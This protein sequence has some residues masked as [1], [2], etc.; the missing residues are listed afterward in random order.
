MNLVGVE[1]RDKILEILPGLEKQKN[2]SNDA[3]TLSVVTFGRV[4]EGHGSKRSNSIIKQINLAVAAWASFVKDMEEVISTNMDVIGYD[5]S[6]DIKEMNREIKNFAEGYGGKSLPVRALQYM[7][8]PDELFQTI[9]TK[10]LYL[11]LSKEEG[12]GLCCVEAISLGIPVILSEATGLYQALKERKLENY[13]LSVQIDGRNESPYFTEDDLYNVKKK[14]YQFFHNKEKYKKDILELQERLED[15]G[16]S[17]EQSAR[18][19]VRFMQIDMKKLPEKICREAQM[20]TCQ[21]KYGDERWF[22]R[23]DLYEKIDS[24]YN[25]K[26]ILLIEGGCQSNKEVSVFWWA[27]SRGIDEGQLYYYDAQ[28]DR[29]TECFRIQAEN[30]LNSGIAS[31][32]KIYIFIVGFPGKEPK[33]Y[34]KVIRQMLKK[35]VKLYFII[36]TNQKFINLYE[37]G[38]Y[39]DF[40]KITIQGLSKENV[41]D[42][43]GL[44]GIDISEDEIEKLTPTE[45]LPEILNDYIEYVLDQESDVTEAIQKVEIDR[46]VP[47][48]IFDSLSEQEIMMAGVLA[49]FDTPFSKNIAEKMAKGRGISRK[50]IDRLVNKGVIFI[51]SKFSYKIPS[52]YKKYLREKVPDEEKIKAYLEISKHY[53]RSYQYAWDD[54]LTDEDIMRGINACKFAIKAQDYERARNY[55][56]EGKYSLK[57]RGKKKGMYKFLIPIMKELYKIFGETDKWLVYDFVH[58]LMITGDI[59]FAGNIL[60]RLDLDTVMDRDCRVALLRLKGELYCEYHGPKET[61]E[62]LSK[63]YSECGKPMG[64]HNIADEQM[65]AYLFNLQMH[66]GL[67]G[68]VLV[69][70]EEYMKMH[71]SNYLNAILLNYLSICKRKIN[72][73]QGTQRIDEAMQLFEKLDDERG[74]AW[75]KMEKGIAQFEK[76]SPEAEDTLSEA[77]MAQKKL[78]ECSMQYRIQLSELCKGNVS[79]T[80]GR[81]L[82]EERDRVRGKMK[83]RFIPEELR[84]YQYC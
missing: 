7:D 24:R 52:F 83:D 59:N 79:E 57:K 62:Y 42:Y 8:D 36:S 51:N 38:R 56:M 5:K 6:C 23:W 14:I 75:T 19:M 15:T 74:I 13:V 49:L 54:D 18:S 60:H 63:E 11:M 65:Q 48:E 58:C 64:K 39:C 16:F 33:E 10:S 43:F 1:G 46:D 12:F 45:Y 21:E 34:L 41:K 29:E 44:Y 50:T 69:E 84:T 66:C 81:L 76:N 35:Y 47:E 20:V 68:K 71:K 25:N 82:E 26:R 30:L 78:E 80:I 28:E 2:F 3:Q 17:W 37:I 73:E 67:Y 4:E 27:K 70:C 40:A 31:D 9:K 72:V 53:Y 22:D 32:I 61:Y 77:I 55:L